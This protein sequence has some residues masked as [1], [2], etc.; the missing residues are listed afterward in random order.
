MSLSIEDSVKKLK[1]EIIAQDWRLSSKRAAGIEEAFQCLRL[2]FKN[3]KATHAILIMAGSVLD[4]VKKRG[5]NPP[6]TI[7][8]LKE[9]MAHVVNLYEDLSFDPEKEEQLFAVVFKRFQR[10]KDKIK[11]GGGSSVSK[12]REESA[13]IDHFA[14][15]VAAVTPPPIEKLTDFEKIIALINDL[16][17]SLDRAGEAGA[18]LG[19]LLAA[20]LETRGGPVVVGHEVEV[21]SE[22]PPSLKVL[23]D[24]KELGQEV[25]KKKV[26]GKKACPPCELFEVVCNGNRLAIPCDIVA[27]SRSL[28]STKMQKCLRD[29]L[30]PLK[31][32]AGFMQ[33]LSR[34]FSGALAAIKNNKLKKLVLPIMTPQGFEFDEMLDTQDVTFLV[35]SEGDWH[36]VLACS[37]VGGEIIVMT[38]FEKRKNGDISGIAWLKD[39]GQIM[40][41]D[42]S[43]ILRREGFLLMA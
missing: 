33:R 18:M 27:L 30:V 15:D 2:R 39:G 19:E 38:E 25:V 26:E 28:P 41:L 4:Y 31:Y 36:G 40:L 37:E 35:I 8:F 12:G 14:V 23:V 5:G 16:K 10:L 6:E 7:D 29:S 11:D 22:V 20:V 13:N 43:A 1:A 32:F 24:D 3:R 42:S 17:K 21:R 34:Q 9:S